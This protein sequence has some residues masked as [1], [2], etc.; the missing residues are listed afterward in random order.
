MLDN[1]PPGAANNPLAPYNQCDPEPIEV[2]VDETVAGREKCAIHMVH[3]PN[4]YRIL[5]LFK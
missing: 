2:E 3:L 4:R 1:Y 5:P